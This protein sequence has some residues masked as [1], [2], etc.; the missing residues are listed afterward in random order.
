MREWLGGGRCSREGYI[1]P[2]AQKTQEQRDNHMLGCWAPNLVTA[3][4][5]GEDMW[6][7]ARHGARVLEAGPVP[8]FYSQRRCL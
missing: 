6:I 4:Q 7:A 2:L 1:D 5:K 3:H 8:L